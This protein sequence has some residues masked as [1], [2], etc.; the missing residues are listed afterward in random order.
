[1]DFLVRVGFDD[2]VESVVFG[3]NGDDVCRVDFWRSDEGFFVGEEDFFVEFLGLQGWVDTDETG[4]K[5]NY[6]VC[7]LKVYGV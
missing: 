4:E 3:I 6:D 2:F 7:F 5:I 1:M